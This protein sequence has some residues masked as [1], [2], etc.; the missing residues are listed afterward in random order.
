MSDS[1]EK[2]NEQRKA[3]AEQHTQVAGH[4]GALAERVRDWAAPAPVD[5]WTARDVVSHLVEWS[6]GLLG[7]TEGLTLAPIPSVAGDPVEAWRRHSEQLQ[8]VLENPKSLD[9]ELNNEHF[10]RQPW[11]QAFENFYL[12]DIFMHSW[13]LARASGQASG[14]DQARC[15]QMLEGMESMEGELR[16]SGQFGERR[17]VGPDA[18]SEERLMAFIGRDPNWAPPQPEES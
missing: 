6:R 18:S 15:A 3:L 14:L 12:N 8:L 1:R 9:L 11:L 13:D 17:P 10:G 5:G 16:A 7:S 2:R 4:F